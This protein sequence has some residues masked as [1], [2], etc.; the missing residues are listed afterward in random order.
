MNQQARSPSEIK[1]Q[2]DASMGRAPADLFL[3][4]GIIV[5]TLTKE[6]YAGD[7]AIKG[8][9]II[10]VGDISDLR[11]IDSTIPTIDIKG[12]YLIPGLID[13]HLHTES[14]FLSPSSFTKVSLPRGT[15]TVVVDP[16]ELTNVL[17]IRGLTLYKNETQDLPQ[18]FLVEIPSCVPAAP[19]LETGPSFISMD[20][21]NTIMNS[22]QYFALAEMMNFP[23][24]IYSDSEVL[25][26]LSMAEKYNMMTEGHAPSLTGKEL[27]AYLTAGICSCHESIGV[28]EVVEKLRLGMKIQL[29][30]GSFARN[31][32]TLAQGIKDTFGATSDAW[33]QVLSCSDDKHADDIFNEGHLDHSLRSLVKDLG[34]DPITAV[35][36]ATR[37]PALHLKRQDLGVIAPGKTANI[38]SVSDLE[39]FDVID[40]ISQGVHVAHNKQLLV[41]IPTFSY[42]DW[43][44]DTVKPLFIPEKADFKLSAPIESGSLEAH[45]IGVLEHSLVT[46]HLIESVKIENNAVM[47]DGDLASFYVL[48][49]HGKSSNFSKSIV[50]GFGFEGEVGLA[51]TVAHDSHQLLIAGNNVDRMYEAMKS[52]IAAK[53]G[54]AISAS[55]GTEAI[56]HTLPL[57]YAGLMSIEDPAMI[58]KQAEKMKLFSKRFVTGISDPFMSLSFMALPVIPKL[59]LTDKGLVDVDKFQLIELFLT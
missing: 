45:V 18:E 58:V 12:K 46:E 28:Q 51:S 9:R 2:I 57:P 7:V 13:T 34:L 26:K 50:S 49:R 21:Y 1:E 47:L 16:H 39:N 32:H 15:T 10:R 52:V 55:D 33:T 31:L 11:S 5:N 22:N 43:A 25:D 23:G 40:V 44:T 6:S 38:V 3:I 54:Q 17:G 30:E 8:K 4:N 35:Q 41:E 59:K 37:N 24:V 19:S 29:R 48:D 14:S 20:E 27:Q 42:P 56:T 53:G 36:I